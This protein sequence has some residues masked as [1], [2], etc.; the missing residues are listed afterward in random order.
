MKESYIQRDVSDPEPETFLICWVKTNILVDRKLPDAS[1]WQLLAA[2]VRLMGCWGQQ[3]MLRTLI[4]VIAISFSF[5]P[6]GLTQ[7][8]AEEPVE[9]FLK[10]L[11]D[12]RHFEVALRYVD[13]MESSPL[14]P[15]GFKSEADYRRGM[16][17]VN[18]ARYTKNP[19]TKRDT[20]SRA[21]EYLEKFLSA[22]SGHPSSALARTQLGNILV[23]RARSAMA[24]A[25]QDANN[26]ADRKSVV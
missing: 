16:L 20:L 10:E 1:A 7:A 2:T 12:N 17:M 6:L 23:E 25:E 8:C 19:A 13:R 9:A 14:A 21:K 18:S 26:R 4:V 11:Q 15:D 22:H 24:Q 5:V 3:S